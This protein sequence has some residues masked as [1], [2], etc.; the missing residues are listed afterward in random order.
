MRTHLAVARA[1]AEMVR[2]IP[3]EEVAAVAAALY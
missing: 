2:G 3:P 1:Q